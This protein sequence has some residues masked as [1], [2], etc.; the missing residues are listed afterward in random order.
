MIIQQGDVTLF[1]TNDGG[2]IVVTDGITEMSSCFA[3]AAYLSL[4]GGNEDDDGSSKNINNWW[5]NLD[6]NDPALQ[7]RSETQNLLQSLVATTGNLQRIEDAVSRD[8]AWFI[9]KKIASSITI[10]I[11]MPAINTIDIFI[12]IIA[13]GVESNFNFTENWKACL[14]ES[15]QIV[16]SDVGVVS[17]T[18]PPIPPI[19]PPTGYFQALIDDGVAHLWKLGEILGVTAKD[20]IASL[21]GTYINTPTLDKQTLLVNDLDPSALFLSS[22]SESVNIGSGTNL[23]L[24]NSSW[25]IEFSFRPNIITTIKG[26]I[27]LKSDWAE[28]VK[29]T[30]GN[31]AGV[32]RGINIASGTLL[33]GVRSDTDLNTSSIYHVVITYNGLGLGIVANFNIYVNS[34]ENSVGGGAVGLSSIKDTHIGLVENG[35]YSDITMDNVSYFPLELT[36]QQALDHYYKSLAVTEN[37]DYYDDTLTKLPVAYWRMNA[38]KN[39]IANT[40]EPDVS[41][42]VNV[43]DL[44][45]DSNNNIIKHAPVIAGSNNHAITNITGVNAGASTPHHADFNLPSA[46]FTVELVFTL[47]FSDSVISTFPIIIQK[48]TV[49]TSLTWFIDNDP[50]NPNRPTLAVRTRFSPDNKI[51]STTTLIVGKIYHSSFVIDDTGANNLYLEGVVEA[52]S[53]VTSSGNN[54]GPLYIGSNAGTGN[55][56]NSPVSEI[57]VYQS[58]LTSVQILARVALATQLI[59]WTTDVQ[60]YGHVNC[61]SVV[62][63]LTQ[64]ILDRNGLGGTAWVN[65]ALS[66]RNIIANGFVRFTATQLGASRL[67]GFNTTSSIVDRTTVTHGILANT[68]GN[69]EKWE[70]SIGFEVVIDTW[71]ADDVLSVQRIGTVVKYYKNGVVINTS[72]IP[73]SGTIKGVGMGYQSIALIENARIHTGDLTP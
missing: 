57:V 51:V 31:I 13:D 34:C 41:G 24:Q 19:P 53:G 33:T 66:T 22:N 68:N 35:V 8:L 20:F 55:V 69:I 62:G 63:P 60:W 64:N 5:G 1:Q 25:S 43:H 37:T 46:G 30:Y 6:E 12:S 21:D 7:Y 2:N 9:N 28:P 61:T 11:T 16:T 38:C 72:A 71:V 58:A 44:T 47:D 52:T 32:F 45:Y 59:D 50:S 54:V 65:G 49:N 42:S 15:S 67:I 3:T 56:L 27:Q 73:S 29:I 4:F 70:A 18:I 48:G 10:Q 36:P 40:I 39:S 14:D 23:A 26:L 17:E